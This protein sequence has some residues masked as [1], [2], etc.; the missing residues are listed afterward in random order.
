MYPCTTRRTPTKF[1][2]HQVTTTRPRNCYAGHSRHRFSCF[3]PFV[4][5]TAVR[6]QESEIGIKQECRCVSRFNEPYGRQ[7]CV[8]ARTVESNQ[9]GR[10]DGG[11]V[12]PTDLIYTKTSLRED[13]HIVRNACAQPTSSSAAIQAQVTP[14]LGAPVSFRT[15]RRRLAVPITWAAFDNHPSTPPLGVVLRSRK[16]DGSRMELG[17]RANP[18]SI[19]AVMTIVFLCGESVVNASILPNGFQDPFFNKTMLGLTRKPRKKK[20]CDNDAL[21]A[22]QNPPSESSHVLTEEDNKRTTT[23]EEV[24]ANNLLEF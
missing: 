9:G 23:E 17:A 24:T 13:R 5:W 15:I 1:K 21:D 19:S 14:S 10:F 7:G 20:L 8:L 2:Q 16:Q 3:S 4:T 18:D 6:D 11:P 12:D 22:L